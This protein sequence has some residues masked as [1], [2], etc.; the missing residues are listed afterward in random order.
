MVTDAQHLPVERKDVIVVVARRE[1][2]VDR[3]GRAQREI[4]AVEETFLRIDQRLAV[5]SPVGRLE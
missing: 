4:K 5:R 1:S 3:L 2:G